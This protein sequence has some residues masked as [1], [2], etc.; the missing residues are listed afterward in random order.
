MVIKLLYAILVLSTIV[1]V[2]VAL[3]IFIRVRCQLS[4]SSKQK[5]S[6]TILKQSDSPEKRGLEEPE[7]GSS[8][9]I[10]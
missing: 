7:A 6:E 1:V 10:A 5:T 2:S 3:T 4:R 9:E 8:T